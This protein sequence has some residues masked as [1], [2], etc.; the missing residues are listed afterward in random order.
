LA[1]SRGG[2]EADRR[3][4]DPKAIVDAGQAFIST[5]FGLALAGD[6]AGAG[7]LLE[8]GPEEDAAGWAL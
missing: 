4:A 2:A 5:E 7:E 3:R 1:P 6:V 8:L